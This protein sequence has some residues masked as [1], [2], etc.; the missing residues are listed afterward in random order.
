MLPTRKFQGLM[1]ALTFLASLGCFMA[2]VYG[3][4]VATYGGPLPIAPVNYLE[5]PSVRLALGEYTP[6]K[7]GGELPKVPSSITRVELEKLGT[8]VDMDEGF[9]DVFQLHFCI[10]GDGKPEIVLLMVQ[11]DTQGIAIVLGARD[12]SE[13][14]EGDA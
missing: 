5:L 8:L 2:L 4:A 11:S 14:H 6:V 13:D 3:I 10:D 9:I 7:H 1:Y 12:I